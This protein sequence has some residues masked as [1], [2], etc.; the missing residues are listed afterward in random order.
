MNM[1]TVDLIVFVSLC[2]GSVCFCIGLGAESKVLWDWHD[3]IREAC[4]V[5]EQEPLNGNHG[6]T[7]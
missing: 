1:T 2:V 5:T 7:D 3:R 4:G 6:V